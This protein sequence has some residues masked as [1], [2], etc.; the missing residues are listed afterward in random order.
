MKYENSDTTIISD[1]CENN[2]IASTVLSEQE[3]YSFLENTQKPAIITD[4]EIR[5]VSAEFKERVNLP[6]VKSCRVFT[7]GEEDDTQRFIERDGKRYQ[8]AENR[9]ILTHNDIYRITA[10]ANDFFLVDFVEDDIIELLKISPYS[11][12][13]EL[14]TPTR[15]LNLREDR[16]NES[17]PQEVRAEL[18]DQDWYEKR[19]FDELVANG[20]LSS[21]NKVGTNLNRINGDYVLETYIEDLRENILNQRQELFGDFSSDEEAKEWYNSRFLIYYPNSLEF[22][23]YNVNKGM[24]ERVDKAVIESG[25]YKTARRL[26][27]DFFVEELPKYSEK[28]GKDWYQ[29]YEWVS[30]LPSFMVERLKKNCR[31]MYSDINRI[32]RD[33]TYAMQFNP[34]IVGSTPLSRTHS[35]FVNV[36][37]GVVDMIT[38][39]LLP[40]SP[41]YQFTYCIADNF[42]ADKP[43]IKPVKTLE[44]WNLALRR[45]DL[46]IDTIRAAL[47]VASSGQG[48]ETQCF[49]EFT[50]VPGSGKG[51]SQKIFTRVVGMDNT[52]GTSLERLSNRFETVAFI[53]KLHLRIGDAKKFLNDRQFIAI[54]GADELALE[55]K[56][57]N[58]EATRAFSGVVTVSSNSPITISDSSLAIERRRRLIAFNQRQGEARNLLEY[59]NGEWTGELADEGDALLTWALMMPVDE[60]K[61]Y[62]NDVA[63]AADENKLEA[64]I[65]SNSVFDFMNENLIVDTNGFTPLDLGLPFYTSGSGLTPDLY[66]AFC[67]WWERTK[68]GTKIMSK[69]EFTNNLKSLVDQPALA[70]FG[71]TYKKNNKRGELR[72]KWGIFGASLRTDTQLMDSTIPNLVDSE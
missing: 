20:S 14:D 52:Y 32:H 65:E 53:D 42:L 36:N 27:A 37:N 11:L 40:H 22:F 33:S 45:P 30:D 13:F 24:Y 1:N 25:I 5:K 44:F 62:L 43:N 50:G 71:F 66:P 15:G 4:L 67:K 56:N 54:T 3:W 18:A 61:Q 63:N 46:H 70:P 39:E 69:R 41:S 28:V 72:G 60:A 57:K 26:L 49:L 58:I 19:D 17:T 34:A 29:P 68:P 9:D 64:L 21:P 55:K 48:N 35:D 8:I 38:K 51:T 47:V 6:L 16:Y 10:E 31:W 2:N 59:V 23:L 12:G 7:V